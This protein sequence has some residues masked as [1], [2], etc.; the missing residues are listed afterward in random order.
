MFVPSESRILRKAAPGG[1]AWVL[2]APSSVAIRS[3]NRSRGHVAPVPVMGPEGAR[4]Y[5]D[6]RASKSSRALP[7]SLC[8]PGKAL[9]GAAGTRGIPR[10]ISGL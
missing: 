10:G 3:I 9:L 8:A 2:L 4:G 7:G 1:R 6:S 5:Q